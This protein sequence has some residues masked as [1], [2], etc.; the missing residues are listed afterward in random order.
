MPNQPD[1]LRYLGTFRKLTLIDFVPSDSKAFA[2]G[3]G[4]KET[5]PSVT[6]FVPLSQA[7]GLRNQLRSWIVGQ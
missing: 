3:L 6:T 1:D 4:A 7:R 5:M 2:D